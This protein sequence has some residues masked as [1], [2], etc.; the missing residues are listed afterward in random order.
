MI[1]FKKFIAED[2]HEKLTAAG[3]DHVGGEDNTTTYWNPKTK[4]RVHVT[5]RASGTTFKTDLHGRHATVG[6]AIATDKKAVKEAFDP[7]ADHSDKY[8][9][10]KGVAKPTEVH[11]GQ[12][13]GWDKPKAPKHVMHVIHRETG[14]EIGKIEPYSATQDKK[15]PGARIVTSRKHVTRHSFS[16]HKGHGPAGHE[17]G[18]Y[19][20]MKHHSPAE[21]LRTMASEHQRHLNKKNSE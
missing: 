7:H 4:H 20:Y 18:T 16:F 9:L 8:Q 15:K 5:T 10:K 1:S 3:Y 12:A 21:A 6:A 17:M 11:S 13:R 14:E 2:Y 19:V